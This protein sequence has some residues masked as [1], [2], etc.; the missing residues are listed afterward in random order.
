MNNIITENFLIETTKGKID[1]D[2]VFNH[3]QHNIKELTSLI[4]SILRKN[5][6]NN[7]IN[8]FNYIKVLIPNPII[9]TNAKFILCVIL[10]DINEIMTDFI[11]LPHWTKYK[12]HNGGKIN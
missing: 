5:I 11:L 1:V 8:Y 6:D 10:F 9:K 12:N 3:K 4:I 7:S 2:V